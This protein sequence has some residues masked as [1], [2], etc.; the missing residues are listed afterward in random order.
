MRCR[1]G[2]DRTELLLLGFRPA[3]LAFAPA[4]ITVDGEKVSCSYRIAGGLLARRAGGTLTLTQWSGEHPELHVAVEG[5]FPRLGVLY[6][7][8]EQRFHVSVSRRY[9]ARLIDEG[10]P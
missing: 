6:G 2:E 7:P 1:E 8:L 5:F 3:L 10:Q 4:R 9:F